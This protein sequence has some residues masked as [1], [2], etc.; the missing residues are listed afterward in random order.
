MDKTDNNGTEKQ[1]QISAFLS[2]PKHENREAMLER[3]LRELVW[4]SDHVRTILLRDRD[5]TDFDH[6]ADLLDTQ[7]IHE[8]LNLKGSRKDEK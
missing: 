4:R 1:T 6:A 7:N 5:R 2:P 3:L 8:L